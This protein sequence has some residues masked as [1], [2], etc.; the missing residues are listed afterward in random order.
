MDSEQYAK[1]HNEIRKATM[2]IAKPIDNKHSIYSDEHGFL[3]IAK[4]LATGEH[5]P[6]PEE[7]PVILFRG[8]D[9]L[10]LP[11]LKYYRHLCLEDHCTDFQLASMDDMIAK[12]EQFTNSSS[13]MKQPGMEE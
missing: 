8:R 6:I 5:I 12:F 13:T 4:R 2:S 9:K 3:C 10:A 1:R 7:E 11:M